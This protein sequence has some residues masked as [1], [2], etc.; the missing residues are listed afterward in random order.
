VGS[1][2][3]GEA[4][5]I[6]RGPFLDGFFLDGV[7]EFDPWV[8]AERARLA[9]LYRA[10]LEQLIA[11]AEERKDPA[12]A[13]RWWK[14]LASHD[15]FSAPTALGAIRALSASGDVGGAVRHARGYAALVK[16]ELGLAPDSQVLELIEELSGRA[17]EPGSVA[18]SRQRGRNSAEVVP[19]REAPVAAESVDTPHGPSW[20]FAVV[21]AAGAALV[22]LLGF[23]ALLGR[24]VR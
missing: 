6:Y 19:P 9:E 15:P 8:E 1:G 4:V 11:E 16:G 14:R 24:G 12:G 2:R 3:L 13:A 23:F 18:R 20:R 10:A 22:V 17:V 7:P 21:V 5:E